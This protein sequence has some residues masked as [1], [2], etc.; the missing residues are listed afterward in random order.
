MNRLQDEKS[1]PETV[2]QARGRRVHNT[3]ALHPL[4]RSPHNFAQQIDFA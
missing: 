4:V 1:T 3:A 2:C